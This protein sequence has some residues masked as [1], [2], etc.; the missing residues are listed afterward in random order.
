MKNKIAA[1]YIA[2][3]AIIALPA[4][5]AVVVTN[6][7]TETE[8]QSVFSYGQSQ[9]VG[10][11]GAVWYGQA[12]PGGFDPFYEG[13]IGGTGSATDFIQTSWND[14]GNNSFSLSVDSA[15][16]VRLV[17]NGVT[18][19]D[20]FEL[21]VV[22]PFNEVWVGLRLATGLPS[23][24]LTVN[25]QTVSG[26]AVANLPDLSLTGA[27]NGNP[28]FSGFK[29]HFDNRLSNIGAFTMSGNLTPQMYGAGLEQWTY[30]FVG[31]YNPA[32]VPEPSVVSL[33]IAS[34]FIILMLWRRKQSSYPP[35]G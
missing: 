7:D 27:T 9:T 30:T 31:V 34:M 33:V 32:L 11:S 20:G 6:I 4:Q 14:S 35:A 29:F 5:A 2:V 25:T 28:Q 19:G 8:F 15:N 26:P 16:Y 18:A 23:D 13:E 10:G 24:I 22:Q 12:Q 17:I 1:L 3:I 21:P